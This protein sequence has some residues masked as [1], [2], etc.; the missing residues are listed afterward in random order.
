MVAWPFP[1]SYSHGSSCAVHP[2]T[3]HIRE[4]V[5]SKIYNRIMPAPE[6]NPRVTIKAIG[7]REDTA[8]GTPSGAPAPFEECDP[9]PDPD[10]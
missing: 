8:V 1:D 3:P 7:M 9:E 2:A 6:I 5:H 4:H 10:C